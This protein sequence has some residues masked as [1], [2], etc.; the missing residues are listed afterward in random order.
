MDT[1]IVK[2]K[3]A[4]K[5]LVVAGCMPQGSRVLKELE[6]VSVVGVQQIDRVIEVVEDTL[7]GHE[8][9]LLNRKILQALDLTMVR[10]NN[11][12]K[13]LLINV[14]CL[15]A[16]TYCKTKHACGH[17]GSYTIESLVEHVRNVVADG[18]KEIWIS[19]KDTGAYGHDIG[20]NLPILLK[21][22]VAELPSDRSKMF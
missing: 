14:G 22:I 4:K 3:S 6:G 19:S 10:K 1:I 9:C 17:L 11:F 5:P 2:C 20:V 15:G 8:V 7:K 16:C 21:A 18:V 12:I 13:I